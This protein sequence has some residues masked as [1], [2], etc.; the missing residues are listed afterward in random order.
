MFDPDD[1]L[2]L[3]LKIYMDRRMSDEAGIRAA[4][5]RCYYS[6]LLTVKPHLGP[7]KPD[8]DDLHGIAMCFVQ[9][10][11][12]SLADQLEYLYNHRVMAD[13]GDD[14]PWDRDV[15]ADAH[16]TA[17]VLNGDIRR[18]LGASGA[19]HLPGP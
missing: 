19:R 14:V 11:D 12:R 8:S 16:A 17:K 3:A 1:N 5:S 4:V 9:G 18:I 10:V 15:I 2:G 13:M 6:S 7:G